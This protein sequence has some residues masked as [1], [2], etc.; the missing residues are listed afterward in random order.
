MFKQNINKEFPLFSDI[1]DAKENWLD[2]YKVES[3]KFH[4][5]P[6]DEL[7]VPNSVEKLPHIK[8]LSNFSTALD[9]DLSRL[10]AFKHITK[11]PFKEIR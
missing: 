10:T 4:A 9:A 3:D 7:S 5:T 1:Q 8:A 11:W 2:I 6:L